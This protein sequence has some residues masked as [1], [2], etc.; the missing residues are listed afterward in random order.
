MWL[1]Q[2]SGHRDGGRS[3]KIRCTS[4]F[5]RPHAVFVSTTL[6][7]VAFVNIIRTFP[8]YYTPINS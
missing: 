5:N 7:E 6:E 2:D 3:S 8:D 4:G 1:L